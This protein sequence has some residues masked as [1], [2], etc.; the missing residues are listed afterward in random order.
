AGIS[1]LLHPIKFYEAQYHSLSVDVIQLCP[2]GASTCARPNWQV[3]Q[4]L[5][6]VSDLPLGSKVLNW[7]LRSLFD[8]EIYKKCD[9]AKSSHILA[10][11]DDQLNPEYSHTPDATLK[12]RDGR[13][14]VSFD[15]SKT[16]LPLN[17]GAK[18]KDRLK[19]ESPNPPSISI[20]SYIGGSGQQ[21]GQIVTRLVNRD[22]AN[23]RAVY[24]HVIPWFLRVYYHTIEMDCEGG[25]SNAIGEGVIQTKKF[26]PA[27]DRGAPYLLE[28]DVNLPA[29]STCHLSIDFDK[30]FL[31]WTEYPPDANKGFFVPSPSLVFR[32]TDW[33]N[34]TVLGGQRTTTMEEL[35]GAVT[36]PLVVMYGEALLVSLPTPDFSMPY[37]VICLVCTV[38]ALCFGPI[39][40]LTTK[41]LLLKFEDKDAPQ[42]L[43]GKLKAKLM[44]IVDKVRRKGK[45]VD[46]ADVN[47]KDE[48]SKKAD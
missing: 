47:K 17:V 24:T 4:N 40:S 19:V 14:F 27:K 1:S 36:S 26:T 22:E 33:S 18:Y 30:S 48:V 28:L 41:C 32:P 21:D 15:V 39:H 10:E 43:L 5:L 9:L 29:Q 20:H 44:K 2:N 46:S 8:G 45:A 38:I 13:K 3:S 12:F 34:V 7:N 35:N 25:N 42:T 6:V 23:H 16:K 11:V 31:R 37:N